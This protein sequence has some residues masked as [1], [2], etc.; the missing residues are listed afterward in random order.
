MAER[1]LTLSRS[2]NAYKPDGTPYYR[3]RIAVPPE[4]VKEL[5]WRHGTELEAKVD[6]GRLVVSRVNPL[7]K[8]KGRRFE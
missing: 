6:N 7:L 1:E 4:L 5:G 3:F 8:A 2:V